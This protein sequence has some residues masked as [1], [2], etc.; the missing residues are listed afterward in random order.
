MLT[1]PKILRHAQISVFALATSYSSFASADGAC[2]SDSACKLFVNLTTVNP[3]QAELEA[4]RIK[5]SSEGELKAAMWI[6]QNNKEFW[7]VQVKQFAEPWSDKD[8]KIG[9]IL[10][11]TSATII[12]AVQKNIDFRR[13]L[14][15]DLI[16]VGQGELYG[17][18][19]DELK[20]PD[21]NIIPRYLRGASGARHYAKMEELEVYHKDGYL[22]FE[23]QMPTTFPAD[24]PGA[25]AGILSTYGFGAAAYTAGTNRRSIPMLTKEA[26][27]IDLDNLRDQTGLETY[28]KRDVVRQDSDGTTT[29]YKTV[30]KTCHAGPLEQFSNAFMFHD[31]KGDAGVYTRFDS[32]V[33]SELVDHLASHKMLKQASSTGYVPK[34][35]QWFLD[36]TENQ[37]NLIGIP[38]GAVSGFGAK[39]LGKFLSSTG[40]FA[41]CQPQKAFK[42]VCGHAP[43]Q[44]DVDFL[45]GLIRDFVDSGY[46]MKEIFAKSAI[47]CAGGKK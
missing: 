38:N 22:E 3:T 32:L 26:L 19:D 27:C 28:V 37:K 2:G 44:S 45:K 13:I 24:Q 1:L 11:E 18:R 29:T 30:C 16:A 6:I 20:L 36:L 39:S 17:E 33:E 14:W 9:A 15:D 47:Y 31:I 40:A 8:G 4:V 12:L 25:V 43:R 46:K 10:D 34:N 5:I 42:A 23:S 7:T 21:G 41:K 35:D